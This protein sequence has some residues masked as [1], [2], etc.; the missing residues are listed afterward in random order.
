MVKILAID[1][2]QDN[3][4]AVSAL[5]NNLIP[6]CEVVTAKSGLEGIKKA[7]EEQPG[8]ILLDIKMPQ[9]DGFEVIEKLKSDETTR[10]IPI[11]LLTAAR[12]GSKSRIK[13]LELGADAFL[14]KPIKEVE[15]ATQ[16]KVALRVKKAEDHLR[17]EKDMLEVLVEERTGTLRRINR[18]YQ[19]LSQC[20]RA[21]VRTKDEMRLLDEIC[22]IA[23]EVC[24]Y[25]LA[26]VG[27]AEQNEDK[28]VTPVSQVGFERGYL[29]SLNITWADT[30]RGRGP[31]GTSIR[32]GKPYI[33]RDI[34]T[35]PNFAPWREEAIQRGYAS[36]IALPLFADEQVLGALNIYAAEPDAFDEDEVELLTQLAEDLAHGIKVIANDAER[37]RL[38]VQ[39]QQ[40]QKMEAVGTLAGGIAHDFNNILMTI[41]GYAEM[42]DLFDLAADSSVKSHLEEICKAANRAKDLVRQILTF[43][44]QTAK[45][46]LNIQLKP[47]VKEAVKFLKASIPATIEIRQNIKSEIG[48][49]F[50]DSAQMH[51]V[52]M[53]LCTNAAHAMRDKGGV[54]E[55]NLEDVDLDHEVASGFLDLKPGHYA[56]LT[57]SDTGHGIDRNVMDRIFDPFF[58][59]KPKGEG[60]G[61]GLAVVHGIVKDHG[62]AVIVESEPEKGT[63]FKIF[64]P[65]VEQ[66]AAES[67]TRDLKTIPGG[68]ET[69]L[70]V[71]DE[72]AL[73]NLAKETLERLGYNVTAKSNG[74]DALE[75]FLAQPHR[76]D[77]VITDQTMPHMTGAGLAEKVTSIRPDIPIILCTGYS[78]LIREEDAEALGIR[79]FVYKPLG[80]RA[81]AE[82]VREVLDS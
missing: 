31:T 10:Y 62:G 68:D 45:E 15:L 50:A 27:F 39:L 23:V 25:R 48:T 77:L 51:Q 40:G 78:E 33:A 73:V 59:T 81:L 63:V 65:R 74:F 47:I 7:K 14:T 16:V 29:E 49:V 64:L 38:E 36:S 71:D 24:G 67:Y 54:L 32:L 69:I 55:V 79:K 13:G 82:T 11:I 34:L 42:T 28:T 72:I 37:K 1:D 9:M 58:T 20:S 53:N 80:S 35:D 8:T 3:L 57:V 30:K 76:F 70:F 26:W 61:M 60:T 41:I 12:T 44:R 66:E 2:K 75:A 19:A 4:I 22:R 5:L 6:E 52:V 18:A 21:V 43:S 17:N 46:R 56:R